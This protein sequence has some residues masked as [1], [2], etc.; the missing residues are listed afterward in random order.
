MNV[1]QTM[2]AVGPYIP[3]S[4]LGV[5][6]V[7]PYSYEVLPDGAGGTINASTGMYAAPGASPSNPTR[8]F[9]TIRVTDANNE[10][11]EARI[12]VGDP[13]LLFCEILCR[14]MDLS[15]DRVRLWDQKIFQ[16]TDDGLYI[17]VSN[18]HCKVFG[19]VNRPADDGVGLESEAWVATLDTLDVD[20]ISR[21]P[22]AR[23]RKIDAVLALNGTYSNTQQ[24]RNGFWISK[25]PPRLLNL[26][27]IDGAA[28]PYRYRM[29]TAI[30]YSYKKSKAVDYFDNNFDFELF[31][32]P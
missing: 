6:G 31:T 18:P 10:T 8:A 30:Q 4:F 26:S 32:N 29:T 7:E 13:L 14:E 17:A 5:G 21:G 3:A 11:A 23:V 16:P 12:L 22:A 19:N 25:V 15:L 28:I 24:E 27:Q 20:L 9:D 1:I 2:R